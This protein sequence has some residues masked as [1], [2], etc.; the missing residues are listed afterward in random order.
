[1]SFVN[2]VR[3]AVERGDLTASAGENLT[4]WLTLPAYAF[5]RERLEQHIQGG[6]WKTL[7]GLFWEVIPFGT[8]GRRGVMAD[9][10][11]ATVNVRTIAESADGLAAYFL[12]TQGGKP[13]G[14]AAV[15]HDTRIRSREFAE[16]TASVLAG[17]G[18][19]VYLFESHRSTPALSFAVRHLG[20][21]VGVVI[22]ASHNPPVDNG[23]KAYWNHGGQVLDPHDRGIIECVES[24]GDI[25]AA[26]FEAAVGDG[27]IVLIGEDIDRA[28]MEAVLSQ[29]LSSNRDISAIFTPL[30]GVGETSVYRAI[31]QAGFD[32]ATIFEPQREPDGNFTNVHDQFP[33]P[34]RPEVFAPAVAEAKQTGAELILAS[35]PDADRIG[36]S[37]RGS[38]GEFVHLTGN[39][40]GALLTD[41]V[42]R[43]RAAAGTLSPDHY[44]VETLVTTQLT[45]EIARSHGL[46]VVDNL[47]VGFK[48]IARTMDEQG[49]DNFVFGTEESLGYLAGQYC[50]DKDAAVAALLFMEAAAQQKREGKTL[51]DRLDELYLEHGYYHESQVSQIRRGPTGKQQ[52]N[53]ILGA[54]RKSPPGEL[55]SARFTRVRDYG[56]HEIR[57]LP[58]N[59]KSKDLPEPRGDLV[60]FDA[61]AGPRTISIAAR[62]S[63]TEPKIKFYFFAKSPCESADALPEVKR[64]T[65]ASVRGVQEALAAWAAKRVPPV[66]E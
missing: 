61:V 22:S 54:L 55:G 42:C 38:D 44:V 57:S 47:L 4:R 34:E 10:G 8:G 7:D 18:L 26:D 52:I 15:A 5:A 1:M 45:A 59:Q 29:S 50:R 11:S 32:A 12:K 58:D 3:D 30:H 23:F 21:D 36:A 62:P 51:L 48:Y 53:A 19:K 64:Q 56:Q 46:K 49:P 17:R 6:E 28:Y 33:N 37:V 31:K 60:I 24:A 20:C 13:G 41:Y 16:L 66:E 43:G 27:R 25:I 63:G 9:Y 2:R 39:Q 35:D 40:I 14:K 65:D